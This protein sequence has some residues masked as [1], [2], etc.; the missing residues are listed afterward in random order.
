MSDLTC[1][2]CG[3]HMDTSS[4]V[5]DDGAVPRP[6]DVT[7]CMNCGGL[8]AFDEDLR[9]QLPEDEVDIY[10]SATPDQLEQIKRMQSYIKARG[11]FQ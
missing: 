4:S 9:V 10:L 8:L 11:R 2:R 3:Y 6:G 7:I 5:M 1:P